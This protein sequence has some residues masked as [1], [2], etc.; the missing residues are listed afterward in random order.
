MAYNLDRTELNHLLTPNIDPGARAAVI[1]YLLKNGAFQDDD[2]DSGGRHGHDRDDDDRGYSH[3]HGRDDDDY[4][5]WG[6][7]H[8][9]PMTVKVDISDGSLPPD[10]A[11]A[12]ARSDD[13]HE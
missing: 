12:G 6:H 13:R 10:L 11:R 1:D 8:H 2:D 9:D 5:R 4:G 3:A 7:H